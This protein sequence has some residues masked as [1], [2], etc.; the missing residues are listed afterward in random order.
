M[1]AAEWRG[2]A[3]DKYCTIPNCW[4]ALGTEAD[5]FMKIRDFQHNR[6]SPGYGS[7][8]GCRPSVPWP[9]QWNCVLSEHLCIMNGLWNAEG[10]F[11]ALGFTSLSVTA[12]AETRAVFLG[13]E[14][15]CQRH[16]R[17]THMCKGNSFFK[18][19]ADNFEMKWGKCWGF[20]CGTDKVPSLMLPC[21][22]AAA[23]L[24]S[25]LVRYLRL[26]V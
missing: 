4:S 26:P 5:S 19:S 16:Q 25:L 21:L 10:W 24:S 15:I 13:S 9:L 1:W 7:N 17:Y 12:V 6:I 18:T 3:M 2:F 20:Q 8:W 11:T 23:I 14:K 22:C